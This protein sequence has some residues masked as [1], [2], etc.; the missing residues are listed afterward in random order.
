MASKLVENIDNKIWNKFV[1]LAKIEG[2]TVGG[3][4]NEVL[5]KYLKKRIK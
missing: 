4:L 1:G 2:K 3:L 5:G